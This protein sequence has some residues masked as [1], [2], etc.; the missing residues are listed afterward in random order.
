MM[1]F[2]WFG[3]L[4]LIKL[5]LSESQCVWG[6][7]LD[8]HGSFL[9]PYFPGFPHHHP[10][11]HPAMHFVILF[12]S[13]SALFSFH[14]PISPSPLSP[15]LPSHFFSIFSRNHLIYFLLSYNLFYLRSDN[16]QTSPSPSL[17]S[18]SSTQKLSAIVP[19]MSLLLL[20]LLP[21]SFLPLTIE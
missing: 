12:L 5:S 19:N 10:A 17:V 20:M 14:S 9:S 18:S 11:M 16:S 7:F 6:I 1:L 15:C 8:A 4:P 2:V 13:C 3:H 21:L